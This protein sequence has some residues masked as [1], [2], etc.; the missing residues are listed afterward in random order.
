MG[1]MP[2]ALLLATAWP[3]AGSPSGTPVGLG[4]PAAASAADDADAVASAKH[5]PRPRIRAVFHRRS[6]L[7][8]LTGFRI[9]AQRV[10]LRKERLLRR[11][12]RR[13]TDNDDR[14]QRRRQ[15][16]VPA[17]GNPPQA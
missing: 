14:P 2:V 8:R 6:G 5:K 13:L 17:P 15:Y 11:R 16:P 7:Y 3:M 9:T 1:R 10:H 4:E 12:H